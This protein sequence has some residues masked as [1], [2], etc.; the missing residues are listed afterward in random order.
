[1]NRTHGGLGFPRLTNHCFL[2]QPAVFPS[3]GASWSVS[4]RSTSTGVSLDY[5]YWLRLGMR[6]APFARTGELLAGTPLY[7]EQN[8][9][10]AR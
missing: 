3:A 2:C 8:A 5:E 9:G 1:M 10:L 6:G 7:G 4:A